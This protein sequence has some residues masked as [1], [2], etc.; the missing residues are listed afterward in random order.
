MKRYRRNKKRLSVFKKLL[1][2]I[3]LIFS[4]ILTYFEL[5]LRP[6]ITDLTRIKAESLATEA[7]NKAVAEEIEKSEI[8]YNDLMSLNCNSSSELSSVSTNVITVNKLKA[9]VSLSAQKNIADLSNKEIRFKA[10]DLS[11]IDLLSGRGYDVPVKLNFSG[12]I[13]TDFKSQFT[14]AGVNQTKHT[15][16][17]TVT[18]NIYITSES[19]LNT[20]SIVT[21]SV[22]VAETIIVGNT[23]ILYQNK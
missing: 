16:Y 8:T 12:S 23:P 10:G 22:P 20:T 19:L 17:I 1:I 2:A 18:A 11:G 6:K 3:I 13:Q 4:L 14:S 15:A 5:N 7:I 21:T 9:A